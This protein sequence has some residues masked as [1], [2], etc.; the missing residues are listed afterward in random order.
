M[1]ISRH[2]NDGFSIEE[3]ENSSEKNISLIIFNYNTRVIGDFHERGR[4]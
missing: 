1:C 4:F 2:F 3:L